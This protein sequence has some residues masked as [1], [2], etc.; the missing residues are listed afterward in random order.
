MMHAELVL[1]AFEGYC[2][3][4]K[5]KGHKADKCTDETAKKVCSDCGKRGHI[6]EDCWLKEENKD[7]RPANYT[8]PGEQGAAAVETGSRVELLLCTMDFQTEIELLNDPDVW[9]GDTGATVHM[10]PHKGGIMNVRQGS[11]ED[12]VTMG[13]KQVE[14]AT[15]VA[16]IPGMVWDKNG[17]KLHPTI[18]KDVAIVPN[19]GY[20]LFSLTK[21]MSAGWK[22]I[23]D[24]KSLK[25]K[26]DKDEINFDITIPTPEGVVYGM[27][28]RRDS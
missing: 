8:I 4:C 18:L 19:S 22:L 26:K 5:K 11:K 9:I 6:A 24:K 1:N 20:N 17:N 21:M 7:K 16:D 23:G 3:I 25:L 10:S 12:A 28:I 27:Y 14:Q 15:E 13:N 2:F